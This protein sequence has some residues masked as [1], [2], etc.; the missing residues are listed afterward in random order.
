MSPEPHPGDVSANRKDQC[1]Q[2]APAFNNV[3]GPRFGLG[4]ME[5]ELEIQSAELGLHPSGVRL[6]QPSH[7]LELL[8]DP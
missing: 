2:V 8:A 3:V 6:Q 4:W 5:G 7:V 1:A